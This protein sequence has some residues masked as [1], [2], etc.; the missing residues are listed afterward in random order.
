MRTLSN[1]LLALPLLCTL[2]ACSSNSSPG[3][4]ALALVRGLLGY[5]PTPPSTN[6][7]QD[8]QMEYDR[9]RAAGGGD[10]CYRQSYE[11]IRKLKQLDGPDLP[12]GSVGVSEAAT[13]VPRNK[14]P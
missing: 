7:A 2:C 5:V 13:P 11:L 10:E 14:E 4:T 12:V 9:C 1:I 3:A 8:L 6:V